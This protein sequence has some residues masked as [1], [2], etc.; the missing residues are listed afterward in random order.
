MTAY[1]SKIIK[2]KLDED[3]LQRQIYFLTFIE[4]LEMILS[5]YTEACKVLL[6]Y[7]KI[8]GVNIKEFSKRPLGI[9]CIQI[10]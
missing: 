4:S 3:L 5:Q 1:K 8:G 10:Y 9:F 6:D 2:L 7:A